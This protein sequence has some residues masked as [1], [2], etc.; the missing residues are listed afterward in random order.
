[1]PDIFLAPS[2]AALPSPSPETHS[3]GDVMD[4]VKAAFMEAVKISENDAVQAVFEQVVEELGP[5]ENIAAS[6]TS[7]DSG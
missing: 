6:R 3:L 2:D 1:M 5:Q 4:A 7:R